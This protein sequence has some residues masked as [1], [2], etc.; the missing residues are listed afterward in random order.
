M[1]IFFKSLRIHCIVMNSTT[2]S[3]EYSSLSREHFNVSHR[4]EIINGFFH[5]SVAV[6]RS[7]H[8]SNEQYADTK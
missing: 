5:G 3:Y 2:S 1:V 4:S 8:R 6:N 7:D